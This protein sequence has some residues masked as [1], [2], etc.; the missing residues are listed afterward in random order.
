MVLA[1]G[2]A[3][4]GLFLGS[5]FKNRPRQLRPEHKPNPHLQ[6]SPFQNLTSPEPQTPHPVL[7]PLP[8]YCILTASTFRLILRIH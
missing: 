1:P 7:V 8:G 5:G 2:R 3:S 4:W 6:P